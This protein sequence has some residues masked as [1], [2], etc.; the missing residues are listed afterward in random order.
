MAGTKGRKVR[1]LGSEGHLPTFS[2]LIGRA[3]TEDSARI[4]ETLDALRAQQEAPAHE[5]VIV[6]RLDDTTSSS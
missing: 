5:V 2:V 6:D 1:T 3:S 4:L